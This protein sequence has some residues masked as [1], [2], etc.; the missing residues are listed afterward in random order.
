MKSILI[1]FVL[2][3]VQNVAYAQTAD[4]T[5]SKSKSA[6]Y[7][8]PDPSTLD[9]PHNIS[10]KVIERLLEG[11]STAEHRVEQ[12]LN[13]LDIS[14]L[15]ALRTE[16]DGYSCYQINKFVDT[17][18]EIG[19]KDKKSYFKIGATYFMVIWH[20]GN[21]LGFTPLYVFGSDYE[22]ISIGAY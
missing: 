18:L 16:T 14:Q 13:H 17:W 5:V 2:F 6:D 4:S 20:D 11:N 21:M 9:D 1:L 15:T 8:C 22:P 3:L 12:G 10:D 19:P 7:T